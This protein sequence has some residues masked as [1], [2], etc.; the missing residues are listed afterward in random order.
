MGAQ[1][2]GQSGLRGRRYVSIT[3][4]ILIGIAAVAV[5]IFLTLWSD[6]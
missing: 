6:E 1:D 4:V 2:R 5:A 3:D